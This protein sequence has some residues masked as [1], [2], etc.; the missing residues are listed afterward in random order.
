M[1]QLREHKNRKF[2]RWE[3]RKNLWLNFNQMTRVWKLHGKTLC[4]YIETKK[5]LNEVSNFLP[6]FLRLWI[7]VE[8][9]SY[10]ENLENPNANHCEHNDHAKHADTTIVQL[11]QV[12]I[13]SLK[14]S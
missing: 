6:D 3:R 12:S 11:R 4:S 7:C 8:K 9:I 2:I 13:A 1:I 10:H 5:L 14:T